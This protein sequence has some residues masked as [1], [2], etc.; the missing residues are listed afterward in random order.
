MDHYLDE[1]SLRKKWLHF[2]LDAVVL[3]FC[4]WYTILDI[5]YNGTP[6]YMHIGVIGFSFAHMLA[7][8]LAGLFGYV[9]SMIYLIL[10]FLYA[11][12]TDITR[13]YMV[14]LFLV[15]SGLA[16]FFARRLW[17][18]SIWKTLLAAVLSALVL[19]DGWYLLTC[20][21]TPTGFSQVTLLG[22]LMLFLMMLPECLIGYFSLFLFYKLAPDR[23]K[24]FFYVGFFYTNHYAKRR[25]EVEEKPSILGRRMLTGLVIDLVV[26]MFAAIL[27]VQLPARGKTE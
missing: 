4:S 19:G 5:K 14:F 2:V 7:I 11:V 6:S 9:H 23:V 17:L 24:D 21:L 26:I 27:L 13:S 20:T 3:V 8:I 25:A 22:L 15:I 16:Y 1:F 12:T 18:K 10:I